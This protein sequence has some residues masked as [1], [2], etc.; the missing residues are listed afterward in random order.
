MDSL[1]RC[2]T[3]NATFWWRN[4]LWL[5][6]LRKSLIYVYKVT[7][8]DFEQNMFQLQKSADCWDVEVRQTLDCVE[9]TVMELS[10]LMSSDLCL[11]FATN[12]SLLVWHHRQDPLSVSYYTNTFINSCCFIRLSLCLLLSYLCVCHPHRHLFIHPWLFHAFSF[13]WSIS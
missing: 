2:S 7:M 13:S 5:R 11:L 8:E 6:W 9:Q 1:R 4:E 10:A 12:G 3:L